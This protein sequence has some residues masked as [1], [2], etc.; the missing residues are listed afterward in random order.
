[1][2]IGKCMAV[3][4]L[5][6]GMGMSAQETGYWRASNN[7]AKSVTGDIGLGTDKV[8]I[9]FS[10]FTIAEIRELKKEEVSALF[11]VDTATAVP[12]KLYRLSI[13]GSKTFL[14]KNRI[15]GS[16]ETQWM[17]TDVIGRELHVA[18]FSGEKM[19]QLTLD[20]MNNNSDMC[21]MF[22]YSR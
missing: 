17:V 15:C 16:D 13:P 5:L 6:V 3:A 11:D 10:L 14:H 19:P 1:M 12:G 22:V 21:G 9:N 7:T 4:V 8:S 2:K 20:A 18:F